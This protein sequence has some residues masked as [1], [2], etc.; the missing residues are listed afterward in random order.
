[1]MTVAYLQARCLAF[2]LTRFYT[3][4]REYWNLLTY[5]DGFCNFFLS[6]RVLSYKEAFPVLL[7]AAASLLDLFLGNAQ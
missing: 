4:T 5:S 6:T 3:V 2:S 1:M 7:S